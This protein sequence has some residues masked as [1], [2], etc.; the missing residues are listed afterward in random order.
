MQL[1]VAGKCRSQLQSYIA[2]VIFKIKNRPCKIENIKKKNLYEGALI[3]HLMWAEMQSKR[4]HIVTSENSS[5]M[6]VIHIQ[7]TPNMFLNRLM[8]IPIFRSF[9][10]HFKSFIL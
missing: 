3:N 4:A 2:K 10:C 8:K 1:K 9:T 5:N 6:S 7:F